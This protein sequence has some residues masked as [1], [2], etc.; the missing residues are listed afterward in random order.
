MRLNC[1]F[2]VFFFIL[3]IINSNAQNIENLS[4]GTDN[5][6]EV[7]SWNI[8]NFPKNGNAT[9]NTLP[10]IIEAIDADVIAVQEIAD[11]AAF[12]Q[13]ISGISGYDAYVLGTNNYINL[14]FVYKTS[15]IQSTNFYEIYTNSQYDL[16]FPRKP[17]VMEFTYSGKNYIIINNHLKAMGDNILDT[18][19]PYDEENRRFTAVNLLKDYINTNFPN[20]KVFIV[21]DL[22][23]EITDNFSNN[24]FQNILNDPSNFQFADF[25]IANGSQNEWSYPTYPSHL[26]HIIITNELFSSLNTLTTSIKTIRLGDYFSGG[27][28]EYDENISDH[29]PLAYKFFPTDTM[30]FNKDFEDQSLT[31]GGW[32][33]TSVVG[34]QE[35]NV[36]DIQYGHNNSYCA[37]ISGYD[38]GDYDNEDWLISPEFSADEFSN[39]KL[40]FWNTSGYTGPGLQ[41]FF[42]NNYVDNVE[43]ATWQ[44]LTNVNWHSGEPFWE[45]K[46]S[47]FIDLSGFSGSS[48]RIAFKY[49]STTADGATWE[50]DDISLCNTQSGVNVNAGKNIANAGFINGAGTYAT[51][52]NVR[53]KAIPELGYVFEEWTENGITVSTN[54]EY[55]FTA[56]ADRNLI[57]N[58]SEEKAYKITSGIAIDGNL[59][60]EVWHLTAPANINE[61]ELLSAVKYGVLW[62]ENYLYVGIE[63]NDDRVIND[64]RQAT[65]TDGIEICIDGNHSQSAGF[66][67][68]DML[69]AKPVKSF[70]IQEINHNYDNVLHEYKS[71]ATGYVMEFAIPWNNINTTPLAGQ[72]IGFNLIVNDDDDYDA[73]NE[74]D[75]IVLNGNNDYADG[76]QNWGEITLSGDITNYQEDYIALLFPDAGEFLISG[77]TT[78]IEWFSSGIDNV[79]IEYSINSGLSWNTIIASISADTGSYDWQTNA[80][81]SNNMLIRISDAATAGL[82]D[83]SETENILSAPLN[84]TEPLIKSLWHNYK[85]PYNAYYPEAS[86]GINGHVGN[87]CGPSSIARILHSWEFPRTGSGTLTFNDYGGTEWSADF[88]NTVYNYDNMPTLLSED[89]AESE[90]TDVAILFLHSIVSMHDIY[91]TGTDLENMS[92]AFS[93]Y[94]N[95]KESTPVDMR[96]HTNAEWTQLLINEIDNGRS[97]LVQ[98]MNLDYFGDWGSNN[99][100]GGHWYHC[101]GYNQDGEFHVV[102]GFG[103]YQYDGYYSI[104]EFPLYSYNVGILIGLEPDFNGKTLSLISP[105]GGESYNVGEQVAINWAADSVS[106]ITIEY[107]LDNGQNWTVIESGV[108]ASLETYTWTSPSTFSDECKIRITDDA[109]INIYDK[110]DDNFNLMVSQLALT[111]PTGGESFVYSDTAVIQWQLTPVSEI[112]IYYSTDN[113]LNWNIIETNYPASEYYYYWSVPQTETD[114]GLIKIEASNDSGNNAISASAFKIVPQN[115]I[116]GP[117][118]NDNNTILSLHFEGNLF[119]QSAFS[120]QAQPATGTISY[121]NSATA[122]LGKAMQ[123]DNYIT[124]PHTENLSLTEDWT[125]EMWFKVEEFSAGLQY[126]LWKPGDEDSYFANYAMLISEYWGNEL[127]AFYFRNEDRNGINTGYFPQLDEWYHVAFIRNAGNE[128]YSVQVRNTQGVLLLNL[129]YNIPFTGL[130]LTSSQDLR[131]GFNF[132]GAIDEVRI[133]DVVRGSLTENNKIDKVFED[134]KIIPNPASDYITLNNSEI[135]DFRITS[136]TGVCVYAGKNLPINARVDTRELNPGFY[137]V[138]IETNDK[139]MSRKLIIKR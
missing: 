3:S 9:I 42:S 119:N 65:L 127:Y 96:E 100:I 37:T 139:T 64:G 90:Y 88:E 133:S 82:Y 115:L 16:S 123:V 138:T 74:P 41:V 43:T 18:N 32:I 55:Y 31:S 48:C 66:D 81:P 59:E 131:I 70:W 84:T 124:I 97:L 85:Y 78:T 134:I 44:E 25:N 12:S 125:I 79:K 117:Y 75:R 104:E 8:E 93:T 30:L 58:F 62:D 50:L 137:I 94:F 5:S 60:E 76:P 26:D 116:G 15:T 77:K 91:G 108:D 130:P 126:L 22:N 111:S 29:R 1:C 135:I 63:V 17:L 69:L 113:G 89:A 72:A 36:P 128:T 20:E 13:L 46:N 27:W 11:S 14:A 71:T 52:D 107:T 10:Q 39:L 6:L 34:A 132:S 103:N 109:D 2:S 4:F 7:V 21:G 57:A 120:A 92:H 56:D 114:E 83:I 40:S 87:G 51:G 38:N 80:S 54:P 35:W 73:Y 86:D 122:E 33:S 28:V 95:Y 129:E 49:T 136:S 121:A 68:N 99:G 19:N 112:N 106:N 98:G 118:V 67:D 53:L 23:D 45:W 101:D 102:V 24:V 105:N 61:N 110:S 47:G